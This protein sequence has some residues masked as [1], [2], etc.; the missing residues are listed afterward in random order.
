MY[1]CY[2][3]QTLVYVYKFEISKKFIFKV[4]RRRNEIKMGYDKFKNKIQN[5]Y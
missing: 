3:H 4:H 2:A 5:L 1:L